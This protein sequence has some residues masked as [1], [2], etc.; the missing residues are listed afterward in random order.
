VL[1]KLSVPEPCQKDQGSCLPA[2]PPLSCPLHLQHSV[3]NQKPANTVKLLFFPIPVSCKHGGIMECS[4]LKFSTIQE[5]TTNRKG[6][7]ELEA[8]P[9]LRT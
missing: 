8:T 2:T 5:K 1:W 6:S 9:Y 7:C 4:S 3:Q